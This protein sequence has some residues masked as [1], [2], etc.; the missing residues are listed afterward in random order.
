[1]EITSVPEAKR[2][3]LWGDRRTKLEEYYT[4]YLNVEGIV[5]IGSDDVPDNAFYRAK[6][7]VLKVTSKHLQFRR[8]SVWNPA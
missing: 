4:K 6:D 5:I 8:E 3:R 1:M 2:E 7:I